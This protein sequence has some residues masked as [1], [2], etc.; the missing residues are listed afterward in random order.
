MSQIR[1]TFEKG[2]GIL[3]LTPTWVP[4]PFNRPGR[5]LRLHPDDYFAMGM[6]RGAIVERWFS[7][8]KSESFSACKRSLFP[9]EKLLHDTNAAVHATNTANFFI[10]F[11]FPYV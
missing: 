11:S 9:P 4:R 10:R 7:S 3:Q 2:Q 5:R 8:I 1:D 6:E